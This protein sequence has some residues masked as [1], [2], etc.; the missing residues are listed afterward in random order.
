MLLIGD[1]ADLLE[2][3]DLF[4]MTSAPLEAT[5]EMPV[6]CVKNAWQRGNALRAD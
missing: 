6:G 5:S 2:N 4:L 3:G 1:A